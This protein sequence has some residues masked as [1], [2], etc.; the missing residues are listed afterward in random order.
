MSYKTNPIL[1]RIKINKG[2]KNPYLPTKTLNYSRDISL[3]FKVYLLLKFFLNLKKIQLVS[4]EIRFDQ[5]NKKI[6]YLRINK[7]GDQS[8][9]RKK[10]KLALN[11]IL[12]KIKTPMLKNINSG[13]IF[14]LYND[15]LA[16]KKLTFWNKNVMHKRVLSKF[17]LTKPKISTWLST[18]EKLMILRQNTKKDFQYS[19]KKKILFLH[20]I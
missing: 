6:L 12:K 15:L 11:K 19:K 1:N 9:K 20:V 14:F 13:S 8:Q 17:W 5:Q 16:F 18:L 3:W 10:K 4:F 7:K 2:W